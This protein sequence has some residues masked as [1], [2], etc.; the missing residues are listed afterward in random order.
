MNTTPTILIIEDNPL[1]LEAYTAALTERLLTVESTANGATGIR[2]AKRLKPGLILLDL[3]I[4]GQQGFSVLETLK[5]HPDT[6][7]I[8]IVVITSSEQSDDKE[9]ALALGADGFYRKAELSL[10]TLADC[11]RKQLQNG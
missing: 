8:P 2:L 5:H 11:I 7:H 1:L 4:H 6:K 3:S 9:R 10:E